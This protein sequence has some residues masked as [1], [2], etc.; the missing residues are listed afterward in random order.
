[1]ANRLT[2]PTS[3]NAPGRLWRREAAASSRATSYGAFV[4]PNAIGPPLGACF[5]IR[6][7]AWQKQ[8][9]AYYTP[10]PIAASLV[11]WAIRS[12]ADWMLDP[13]CGDGR[14]IR[15]HRNSG[16]IEQ[17]PLAAATATA[18]APWAVVHEAD[19]FAWATHSKEQFDCAAGNPPFIRYRLLSPWLIPPRQNLGKLSPVIRPLTARYDWSASSRRFI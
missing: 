5:A 2:L 15:A 12:D 13:A 11:R 19:F 16:G 4:D 7:A 3:D 1:M 8:T 10:D 18:V 9:G 17:D 6:R 14:F